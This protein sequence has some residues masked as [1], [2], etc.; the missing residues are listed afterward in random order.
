VSQERTC[1]AS[2][3]RANTLEKAAFQ[4]RR[5]KRVTRNARERKPVILTDEL[6]GQASGG[7]GAAWGPGLAKFLHND[8][9]GE[10]A[11]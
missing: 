8:A 9:I 11:G 1:D 7:V 5:D 10:N 4:P 2:A 6:T 3:R